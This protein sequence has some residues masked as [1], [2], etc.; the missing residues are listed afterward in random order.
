M[1]RVTT[2]NEFHVVSNPMGGGW[3]ASIIFHM[4]PEAMDPEKVPIPDKWKG[5]DRAATVEVGL[6][7][8]SDGTYKVGA[9]V[10]LV[11]HSPD[12][13]LGALWALCDDLGAWDW[14]EE[15]T[16]DQVLQPLRKHE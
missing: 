7:T 6:A 9:I 13:A 10:S 16:V 12:S 14:N 3:E 11:S 8:L 4:I 5:A 15:I 1:H 2:N